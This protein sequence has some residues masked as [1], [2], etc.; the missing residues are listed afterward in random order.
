MGYQLG[1]RDPSRHEVLAVA[2]EFLAA[3][4]ESLE[5]QRLHPFFDNANSA[6][7]LLAKAEL[8]SCA[9]TIGVARET[10]S[11]RTL[12]QAYNLWVGHLENGD[13]R[14]SE[15]LNLLAKLRRQARYLTTQLE[16]DEVEATRLLKVLEQMERHVSHLVEAPMHE[17]PGGFSVLAT[18]ELKAGELLGPDAMTVFPGKGKAQQS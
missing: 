12:S 2:R 6:V 15:A 9:P 17:L 11:H 13:C 3:A 4:K 1:H 18:R 7:E 10:S 14:F 5:A 8:L 16:G